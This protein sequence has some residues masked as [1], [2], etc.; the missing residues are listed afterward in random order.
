MDFNE[1]KSAHPEYARTC[2][3]LERESPALS[4]SAETVFRMQ[5][6]R[7]ARTADDIIAYLE[8][9]QSA[10]RF[11]GMYIRR[12]ASLMKMQEQFDRDPRLE[13]LGDPNLL[14]PREEYNLALLLSIVFSNHRFEIMEQLKLFL[15]SLARPRGRIAAVGAGAG[16]ELKLIAERLPG[17]ESEGYD[18]DPGALQ[19]ANRL[20][21]YFGCSEK[22]RLA[23]EFP[24]ERISD[25]FRGAYDGIVLCEIL[26]HLPDPRAALESCRAYLRSNGR[27]FV[28]MAVNL[29]QEDHIY[30]YA[31]LK[32]CREQI[33]G[34]GLSVL[35]EWVAPVALRPLSKD[36]NR[37][38]D[39][40]NGNYIAVLTA[41]E[42]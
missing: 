38:T 2:E 28:T 3:I 13:T 8:S 27:L 4:R 9:A 19:E 7:L 34:A 18:L 36:R 14:I 39:F 35:H 31:D 37:E 41:E 11:M 15:E 30:L 17:W 20:L 23:E 26:E 33:S 25:E 22:I 12:V 16:W 21:S 10:E 5:G 40:R 42:S 24:L 32:S 6:R 29:A 1:F